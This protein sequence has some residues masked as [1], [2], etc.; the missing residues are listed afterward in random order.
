MV[1]TSEPVPSWHPEMVNFDYHAGHIPMVG[2]AP[3][4]FAHELNVATAQEH[5]KGLLHQLESA[6]ISVVSGDIS[7]DQLIGG[8]GHTLGLGHHD[9]LHDLVAGLMSLGHDGMLAGTLVAMLDSPGRSSEGSVESS[10]EAGHGHGDAGHAGS[11]D[12]HHG[13]VAADHHDSG[14][15]DLGHHDLGHHDSLQHDLGHHDLIGSDLPDD[16]DSHADDSDDPY[17]TFHHN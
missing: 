10:F 6:F 15:H 14:F 7:M 3:Y 2:D 13:D 16:T 12:W 5:D 4:G 17:G 1:A 11:A 8:L 9:T